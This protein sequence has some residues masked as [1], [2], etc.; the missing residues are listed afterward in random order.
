MNVASRPWAT[1][2]FSNGNT[3]SGSNARTK[4]GRN[5]SFIIR[6]S[7]GVWYHRITYTKNERKDEDEGIGINLNG[8]IIVLFMLFSFLYLRSSHITCLAYIIRSKRLKWKYT[9]YELQHWRMWMEEE[10]LIWLPRLR[11]LPVS[12]SRKRCKRWKLN[13]NENVKMKFSILEWMKS[14]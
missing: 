14:S 4:K 3:K 8:F 1:V 5:F 10:K 11:S 2:T 13:K 6:W 7:E 9:R 12:F